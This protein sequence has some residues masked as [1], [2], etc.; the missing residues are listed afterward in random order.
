MEVEAFGRLCQARRPGTYF[1]LGSAMAAVYLSLTLDM[2]RLIPV[3]AVLYV[4]LL[5]ARLVRNPGKGFRLGTDRIDWFTERGRRGAALD[6]LDSVAIGHGIDGETLCVL[7]LADGQAVP[8]SGVET[9]NRRDLM[10]EFGR[11]GVRI[12]G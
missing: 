6:D 1:A 3:L 8:L 10:R 7:R 4:G 9:L 11:R 5:L 12:M 2:N